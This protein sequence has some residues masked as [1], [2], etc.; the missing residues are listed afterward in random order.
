MHSCN[1]PFHPL[2]LCPQ[3]VRFLKEEV[4]P[5][6]EAYRDHLQGTLELQL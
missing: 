5:A 4:E 2:S 3:V 1:L 6:L